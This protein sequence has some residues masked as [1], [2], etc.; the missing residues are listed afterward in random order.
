MAFA[1]L[2]WQFLFFII[3]AS[4]YHRLTESCIGFALMLLILLIPHV[5]KLAINE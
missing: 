1:T 2:K 3:Q 4:V 5:R